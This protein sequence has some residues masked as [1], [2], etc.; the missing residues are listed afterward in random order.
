MTRVQTLSFAMGVGLAALT[1][2]W[3][4]GR[5]TNEAPTAAA[6]ST[7]TPSAERKVLYYRN[8]MGL[9][10][11]SPVPK[12][13][14]MGMNYVPVYAGDDSA[15]APGTVVMPPDKVQ[16]LGVRTEAVQRS[17][18]AATVR[19]SGTIEIDET[20]QYAIAPRFEGWVERLY[21]NQTGMQ[22]RRGQPLLSVYSPQLAAAQQEYR[23]ADETA[24]RLAGSDPAS[25]KSMVRLR[26][27]ARTRLRNWGISDLRRGESAFVLTAP[28]DAVVI[29]KPVI[30]GARF[31]PGEIILRLADLS[32][33]WVMAKVPA[34]QAAGIKP[35]QLARFETVALPGR[36]AEGKVTFVQHVVDRTTHTVDV[37]IALPNREGELRPGLYGTVLLEEPGIGPVLNVARSAVLES[38]TRQVVF[39]EVGRGRFAPRN[40]TL[41]R[42][43]GNRI[44]ILDGLAE[45]EQVV[46]SANF[47]IDAESNLQS[48]LQGVEG[49]AGHGT[50]SGVAEDPHGGHVEAAAEPSADHGNATDEPHTGHGNAAAESHAGHASAAAKPQSVHDDTTA[51]HPGHGGSAA[52]PHAGHSMPSPPEKDPSSTSGHEGH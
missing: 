14:P 17:V 45:N 26:D 11:T 43:S 52:D 19:T 27:A 2:G 24:R 4:V 31:E 33:V 6:T 42:R 49:H 15:A 16:A 38:G 41:G 28:A 5:A 30:Q 35:G 18:L 37:R 10:D 1:I 22:V 13:D 36:I 7:K 51:A 9:P 47:L 3:M 25:A 46:V 23:L 44:E 32:T 40:V 50:P 39:V 20:R 21:A 12:K 34:A 8:P 29:E 48:A